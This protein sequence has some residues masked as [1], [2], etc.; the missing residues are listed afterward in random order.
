MPWN[1]TKNKLVD[2]IVK[3]W[4]SSSS[5]IGY[6]ILIGANNKE[7]YKIESNN[8]MLIPELESNLKEADT[9][10]FMIAIS[11]IMEFNSKIYLKV[12]LTSMRLVSASFITSAKQVV[13]KKLSWRHY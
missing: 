1:G 7:A 11:K 8:Y 3:Q 9:N 13:I 6:K 5:L 10:V 12:L 2:F 4:V